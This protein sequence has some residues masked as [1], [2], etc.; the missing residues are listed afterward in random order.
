MLTE[1]RNLSLLQ[2]A[3]RPLNRKFACVLLPQ[4]CLKRCAPCYRI[5]ITR[6][7]REPLFVQEE[8]SIPAGTKLDAYLVGKTTS[9]GAKPPSIEES[10]PPFKRA[11]VPGLGHG[12]G[13]FF[14]SEDPFER[15]GRAYFVRRAMTLRMCLQTTSCRSTVCSAGERDQW[16][17]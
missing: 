9:S 17:D 10:N 2:S 11:R 1:R 16:M 8:A 12:L 5:S 14:L 15:T 6:T 4:Q 3:L 13:S 7:A